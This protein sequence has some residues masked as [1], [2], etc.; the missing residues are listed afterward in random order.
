MVLYTPQAVGW[1]YLAAP[2]EKGPPV[3]IV[4]EGLAS[5]S[6]PP[7]ILDVAIEGDQ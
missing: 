6:E 4:R 2:N 1:R 5:I 3:P 7:S